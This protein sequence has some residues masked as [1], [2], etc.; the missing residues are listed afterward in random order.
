M[1]IA[2]FGLFWFGALQARLLVYI[3]PDATIAT[4]LVVIWLAP[5]QLCIPHGALLTA[6]GPNL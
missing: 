1:I 4:Q 5:A 2:P 3:R 6:E